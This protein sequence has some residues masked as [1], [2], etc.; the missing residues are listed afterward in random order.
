[1]GLWFR[2]CVA[3][4]GWLCVAV[5]SGLCIEHGWRMLCLRCG[6]GTGFVCVAVIQLGYSL[7]CHVQHCQ[8]SCII[9]LYDVGLLGAS[10][11]GD[12]VTC[13]VWA[14]VSCINRWCA[15][16]LSAGFGSARYRLS[17]GVLVWGAG[18]LSAS[19]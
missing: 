10:L 1:V 16:L 12:G 2:L 3:L 8:Y 4:A 5:L 11:L 6:S 19:L 17:V 7:P 15:R 14:S 18:R 13:M 9:R